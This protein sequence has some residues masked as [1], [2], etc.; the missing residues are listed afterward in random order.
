M[1]A[2]YPAAVGGCRC[3]RNLK[4]NPQGAFNARGSIPWDPGQKLLPASRRTSTDPP[5]NPIS[6]AE[7]HRAVVVTHERAV[8]LVEVLK[9]LLPTDLA[10][11][12]PLPE[13]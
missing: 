12:P 11:T 6:V 2:R 7:R 5:H 9:P 13:N 1:N 4:A 8:M 10:E 3:H